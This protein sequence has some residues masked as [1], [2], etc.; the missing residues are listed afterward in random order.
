MVT[1]RRRAQLL[2]STW[3]RCSQTVRLRFTCRDFAVMRSPQ[4][5]VPL[6][7]TIEFGPALFRL[8]GEETNHWNNRDGGWTD[9]ERCGDSLSNPFHTEIVLSFDFHVLICGVGPWMVV[10]AMMALFAKMEVRL[11][12][13]L[14]LAG[15]NKAWE[16]KRLAMFEEG[17]EPRSG[18]GLRRN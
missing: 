11:P 12:Q 1:V 7:V 17:Q 9:R 4:S 13:P 15:L 8:S 10:I 6:P 16:A 5:R 18:Q 2:L 3:M 14:S